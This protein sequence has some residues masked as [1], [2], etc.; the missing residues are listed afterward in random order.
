MH[1]NGGGGGIE[2]H[3][4]E[5]VFHK[6][7]EG[8]VGVDEIIAGPPVDGR[9]GKFQAM[10]CLHGIEDAAEQN[11]L[12]EVIGFEPQIDILRL[13]GDAVAAAIDDD[14]EGIGLLVVDEGLEGAGAEVDDE[15]PPPQPAV[16]NATKIAPTNTMGLTLSELTDL[17]M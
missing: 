6:S 17:I 7:V 1:S 8:L 14:V 9:N 10:A 2:P 5:T 15:D 3:G 13:Q 11:L 16:T 12:V 4:S